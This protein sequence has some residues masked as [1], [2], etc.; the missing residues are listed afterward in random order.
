MKTYGNIKIKLHSFLGLKLDGDEWSASGSD[1]F[2]ALERAPGAY[3]SVVGWV[4]FRAGQGALGHT[5]ENLLSL[6][7]IESRFL[8]RPTHSLVTILSELPWLP[9]GY[10][11]LSIKI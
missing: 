8:G 11:A 1:R 6:P 3:C 5:K 4:V 10:R 2:T 7:G 9:M